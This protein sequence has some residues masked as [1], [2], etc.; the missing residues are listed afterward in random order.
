MPVEP[1]QG[2]NEEAW[3]A[4]LHAAAGAKAYSMMYI[5]IAIQ[6]IHTDEYIYSGKSKFSLK[7]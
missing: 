5:A 4:K 2:F 3:G 1:L 6:V 7:Y